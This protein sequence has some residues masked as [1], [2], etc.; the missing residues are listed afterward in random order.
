MLQPAVLAIN[1]REAPLQDAKDVWQLRAQASCR[2]RDKRRQPL[3]CSPK[4]R[5]KYLGGNSSAPASSQFIWSETLLAHFAHNR[6][7]PCKRLPHI[8]RNIARAFFRKLR[9]LLGILRG[10]PTK[11]CQLIRLV[12]PCQT[13][14]VWHWRPIL[15]GVVSHAHLNPAHGPY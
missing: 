8:H 5:P 15:R 4:V 6:S 9:Q 12:L 1:V 13:L 11:L 10:P 7:G 14:L 3:R 2:I